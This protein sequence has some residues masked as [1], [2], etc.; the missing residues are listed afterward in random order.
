M[1]RCSSVSSLKTPCF[2]IERTLSSSRA[3]DQRV[4]DRPVG[5]ADFLV[6]R[7]PFS[8]PAA[9]PVALRVVLPRC[10]F[11]RHSAVFR[12]SARFDSIPFQSKNCTDPIRVP[13]PLCGNSARRKG[14]LPNGKHWTK[15]W[16]NAAWPA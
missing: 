11:A 3:C 9:C 15:P 14:V 6:P 12:R 10:S 13:F 4:G 16:S 8:G 7:S 2:H 5:A 1:P